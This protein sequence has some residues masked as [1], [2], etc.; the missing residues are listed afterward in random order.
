MGLQRGRQIGRQDWVVQG[1][2]VGA[3]LTAGLLLAN[4]SQSTG[5]RVDARLGVSASERVVGPGEA[6]PKGGGTYRVG[7]PY[8]VAG[9]VYV[10]EENPRYKAEG[11][12]SWYGDDFH[13]RKTANGEIFDM[14][15]IS[16]AHPTLPIPSYVRVTNLRNHRSLIVRVNDRGP[17]AHDR[18]IDLSTRAAKLLEFHGHGIAKVRVEYVGKAPL[19]GSDDMKLAATLRENGRPV[20]D[21][22]TAVAVA[23]PREPAKRV[24]VASADPSFAPSLLD[25]RPMAQRPAVA[26]EEAET[27]EAEPVVAGNRY[28]LA[29][30]SR[31]GAV[32]TAPISQPAPRRVA[33]VAAPQNPLAPRNLGVL[34][35]SSPSSAPSPVS[36]YA[37]ARYDGSAGLMSGRGLY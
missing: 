13:G 5:S 37:P 29:S 11:I 23:A 25:S 34:H 19:A 26:R 35:T 21:R 6:V 3:V 9:R 32:E 17:Y 30:H 33:A 36:A 28:V 27:A 10:P 8:T 20:H 4:C 2:R 14:T 7:K 18:I 1:V 15:S 31:P 24:A 12:A 16:A 22:P